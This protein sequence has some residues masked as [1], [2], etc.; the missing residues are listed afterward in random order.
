MIF[1]LHILSLGVG[2]VWWWWWLPTASSFLFF[3]IP[4]VWHTLLATAALLHYFVNFTFPWSISRFLECYANRQLC[5]R[6]LSFSFPWFAT[7]LSLFSPP[8]TPPTPV[9][10]IIP[11][12][13][14]K[15]LL[16]FFLAY[17]SC[18]S[19]LLNSRPAGLYYIITYT[20][21]FGVLWE[22][23]NP[24]KLRKPHSVRGLCPCLIWS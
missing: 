10:A 23:T 16:F 12:G 17:S 5:N 15:A 24:V 21:Q 7:L 20:L 8:P 13:P 19:S 18:H 1:L 11:G 9:S 3:C 2:I 6:R 22:C 4:P 14:T